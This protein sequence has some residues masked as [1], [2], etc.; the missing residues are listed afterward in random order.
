[1]AHYFTND[2]I[3]S[4]ELTTKCLINDIEFTFITDNGVFAKKGL[5]YGTKLLLTN[6]KKISGE[7]LDFGCGYGPIGIYISKKFKCNVDMIDINLRALK[8]A[9]KNANINKTEVNIFESDLYSNIEKK[10]DH[11]VTNPPIRVG[12]KILY[13]ILFGAQKYLKDNGQLWLVIHKDQGAKT[14]ISELKKIYRVEII[15]KNKGFYII[16]AFNN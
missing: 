3:E 4:K 8:L 9:T 10:Y 5:D 12:K 16:C 1:M 6:L 11:I 13:E 7:V 15:E 14:L 2:Y